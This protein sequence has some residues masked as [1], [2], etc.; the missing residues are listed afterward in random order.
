M[1]DSCP[2]GQFL[3]STKQACEP[4]RDDSGLCE[5]VT[6][7]QLYDAINLTTNQVL[8]LGQGMGWAGGLADPLSVRTFLRDH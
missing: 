4:C 5:D 8:Y 6:S 7:C 2:E 1:P 3:N